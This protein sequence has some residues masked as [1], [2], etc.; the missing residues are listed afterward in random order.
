MTLPIEP[1]LS[2]SEGKFLRYDAP[3]RII[4]GAIHYFRV[5]PSQ[6]RDRL[7]RLV[8]LGVNTLDTYVAW[9]FHQPIAGVT[10]DFSEWR[11]LGRFI[12]L[13]GELGLDV[14]VRPGPYI[15]AEW[16]NGGFPAW[17]TAAPGV[18]LRRRNEVFEQ[19]VGEWFDQLIPV[20]AS[21]QAGQG[22]PV[23]AVQIE[24]E[25]GS[26]GDDASYIRW[27]RD[28][29]ET[30]GI[31][32]LMFTADG[33]TDYYLDGGS[34]PEILA[35]A[36]LGSRG[37]ESVQTWE[38]RRP[39]E[40]FFAVEFWNGWFDHWGEQH[41]TRDA[42]E[43]A[44]E[45]ER[46][47]ELGGSI[48]LYM[49]HGGSNFGLGSGCNHDGNRLQPTVSSY[50]SDAPIAEDGALTEKFHALRPLFYAALGR[51]LPELPAHLT[52][53]VPVL[54]PAELPLTP[55]AT[56]LELARTGGAS[57]P[58]AAIKSTDPL[59][60]EELGLP[61]GLVL[62]R[63]TAVL[64]DREVRLRLPGLS[65]RATVW[66]DGELAGR[67]D[68][69]TAAEGLLTTGHGTSV[70][71]EIL[72]ESLGHINYGPLTGAGKGLPGGVL[73]DQR[74]TF[75]WEHTVLGL[76]SWGPAELGQL[77]VAH[78][79]VDQPADAHVALPGAGKGFLWVNGSLI[80]RYWGIGPQQSL[81]VPLGFW[82]AGRNEVHV[83]DLERTGGTVKFL[84]RAE[85]GAPAASE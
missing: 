30:R 40:P 55:G 66:I 8:A 29:L 65:D 77:A 84:A 70:V 44:A 82:R 37:E 52:L 43:V 27:N 21:R 9:N 47:L 61:N 56:L 76:E 72:V 78:V 19:L 41:H 80:G 81:Y 2:W 73:V 85:L 20:I 62:Y 22:G 39:G 25:Y 79:D 13:A 83:L 74:Y 23:V 42:A 4:A 63:S 36:T 15:C 34:V 57:A 54:P 46:I 17:V 48:C 68:D 58:G 12:D 59:S 60:F 45:V 38:R 6:W 7:E 26:Y 53:P 49:A 64:P 51:A 14:I 35:A 10:P 24:N 31:T 11:D 3:H 33:G 50:D 67:L 16:D 5:H 75:D 69:G 18:R 1:A 28:A 71:L 32:E